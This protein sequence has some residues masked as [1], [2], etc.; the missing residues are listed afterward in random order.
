[1]FFFIHSIIHMIHKIHINI[2]IFLYCDTD[3]Y[4]R[5]VATISYILC[6]FVW[7][8]CEYSYVQIVPICVGSV[9]IQ[10]CTVCSYLCGFCVNTAMYSLFLFV[11]VLCEYSNVLF[12]P[13]CVGSVWMQLCTVCS[14][15]CEFCVNTAM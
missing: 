12:V 5:S 14:Y 6:F 15:L 2:L 8:L 9:W 1:M 13:I 3:V 11:W 10:L 7:V 4:T